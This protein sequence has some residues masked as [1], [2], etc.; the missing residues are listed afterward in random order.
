[1]R[2]AAVT[3]QALEVAHAVERRAVPLRVPKGLA[4]AFH[5]RMFGVVDVE[6]LAQ[7]FVL[8]ADAGWLVDADLLGDRQVEREVQ[9][10]IH[11]PGFRR[12]FLLQRT[13]GLPEERVVFGVLL[14]QVGGDSLGTGD[15]FTGAALAPG[16]AEKA[17][18]LFA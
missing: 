9:E 1:M 15:D 7:S 14:D 12:E 2:L 17:A 5:D 6:F 16:L 11:A 4:Q 3:A 8:G 13:L 10:R 18:D